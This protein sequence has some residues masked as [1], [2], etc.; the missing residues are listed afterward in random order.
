MKVLKPA[1]AG[2]RWVSEKE[3]RAGSWAGGFGSSCRCGGVLVSGSVGGFVSGEGFVGVGVTLDG[4]AEGCGSGLGCSCSERCPG[5]GGNGDGDGVDCGTSFVL[6]DSDI[7]LSIPSRFSSFC[8]FCSGSGDGG[9]GGCRG[10]GG[11][12]EKSRN[13]LK[14]DRGSFTM[15]HRRHVGGRVRKGFGVPTAAN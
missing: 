11:E 6:F 5:G 3:G 14:P 7:V 2:W 8:S 10:G 4:G 1:E 15:R 12:V 9:G 13:R